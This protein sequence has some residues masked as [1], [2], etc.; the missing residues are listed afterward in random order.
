MYFMKQ[1]KKK[2]KNQ[3]FKKWN[4]ADFPV[5]HKPLKLFKSQASDI[6]TEY[7]NR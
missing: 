2:T 5:N 1:K 7:I 4:A 6:E 3:N